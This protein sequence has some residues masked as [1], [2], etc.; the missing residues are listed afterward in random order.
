LRRV[1]T[2]P[3]L[4][5][6]AGLI[7]AFA[8]T[9]ERPA[10]AWTRPSIVRHFSISYFESR[11]RFRAEATR[12]GMSL[13]SHPIKARGPGEVE[14]TIDVAIQNSPEPSE[15][16]LVIMSGVHG[17]E[18]YLGSAA[19]KQLL[20]EGT[21]R[22]GNDPKR[23]LVFVHAVNPFGFA[24]SRRNNED[25][26]DLNRNLP[27]DGE[28]Y[29]GT[30][31]G[32]ANLAELIAPTRPPAHIDFFY[33]QSLVAALRFG[34][35][36]LV[37][38][39]PE[40]QYDHPKGLFFGG[41][42]I[43]ESLLIW[44][45]NVDRWVGASRRIVFVDFHT[46][47][48]PWKTYQLLQDP[49][50]PPIDNEIFDRYFENPFPRPYKDYLYTARGSIAKWT[51]KHLEGRDS[52]YLVAEFGTIDELRVLSR[53][54]SENQNYWWGERENLNHWTKEDLREAFTPASDDWRANALLH[55][56]NIIKQS[57][58]WLNRPSPTPT[59]P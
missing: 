53:L 37:A 7:T 35:K 59:K 1:R 44:R 25:N 14:L 49:G 5:A 29:K 45:R 58:N 16:T 13:E 10:L 42:G 2:A 31:K 28:G 47:L 17:A 56:G 41:H 30:P 33:L 52:R 55:A 23:R 19:Q 57:I 40:G 39:I 22:I 54:R 24:W 12:R 36:T 8:A 43:S 50:V 18:G 20:E 27:L 3:F 4:A 26:I 9:I 6:H 51:T 34:P 46:G 21:E 32:Y 48:F 38:E 11:D 15:R